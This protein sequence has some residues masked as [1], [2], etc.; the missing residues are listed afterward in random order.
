MS[1]RSSGLGRRRQ[2]IVSQSAKIEHMCI[3]FDKVMVRVRVRAPAVGLAEWMCARCCDCMFCALNS[4]NGSV[5]YGKY[6]S[7]QPIS[8]ALLN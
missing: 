1:V 7:L 4:M 8:H 5:I 2:V 6:A 3:Q